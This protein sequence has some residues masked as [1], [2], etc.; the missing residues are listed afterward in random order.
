MTVPFRPDVGIRPYADG[1]LPLLVRLLGDPSMMLHLG[2]PESP[3][4]LGRR[5]DRYLRDNA[6]ARGLFTIVVGPKVTP[7][8]WA[9]YWES[10]W[11]GERV[12]ECGWHVLREQQGCGVGSAGVALMLDDARRRHAHR[13]VQAFPSVDNAASNGLCRRLGFE[14][15]GEVDVEY[16]KGHMMRS[17]DWR[18]DLEG[19][20][21]FRGVRRCND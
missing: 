18:L 5:H 6:T 12:W 3:E 8:G 16:P 21:R 2:G 4:A 7:A 20:T 19:S 1:D 13:F 14:L 9:G 11:R 10:T 15:L 17:C